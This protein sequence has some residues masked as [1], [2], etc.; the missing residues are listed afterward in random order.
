[1]RS[2][3]YGLLTFGFLAILLV[4]AVPALAQVG[5][6]RNVLLIVADDLGRDLG[7]YGN[8]Q[9]KTPRLDQLAGRGVR[10]DNAFATV[11]SC[12][13]SRAVIYSG[14]YTHT[15]GQFGHA[16]PP[17]NLHTH[18]WVESLPRVLKDRGYRTGIIG[19]VH[20]LPPEVYPFD[21]QPE[22][23]DPGGSHPRD[24]VALGKSAERFLD[25][26]RDQPFLLVV[27]FHDP[28]RSAAGFGNEGKPTKDPAEVIYKPED[29][30][31][32]P[33]LPDSPEV[34]QELAEYYQAVSRLDRGTGEVLDALKKSGRD[35]DT[36]VIFVSD[37]G[38][39]FPGAKTT[40]YDAG[41][42]L[43]LI[44]ASPDQKSRGVTSQ[45]MVSWVDIVP[46]ALEWT[47]SK[48]S[49]SLPGRSLLPI[50]EQS[51]PQGWDTVYGSFVFHEITNYYPMRSIRTRR[52]KYILN[53]A[54]ALDFPFASDLHDSKTWQG[55][56]RRGDTQY[57]LRSVEQYVHRPLEELYDLE[58]DPGEFKNV[59]T[60]PGN[61]KVLADLRSQLRRWQ[62]ETKDPWIIK[63]RHE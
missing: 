55:A 50:L 2:T 8:A 1:M 20:V 5:P 6:R 42:R 45:A 56:V 48:T 26:S 29:V 30:K 39:P 7:C 33:F 49:Y 46:T 15:N 31:V 18:A 38:I 40:L 36:L 61:A 21:A 41:V 27:G 34:R 57:G 19:K 28:H 51:N 17:A 63:Y 13:A 35:D 53:L 37:N 60:D 11:A 4:Q 9:V 22:S 32:P 24:V 54:H 16:H 59:A 25:A 10:F 23:D 47:K 44:V 62:Q 52:Y 12:S 58:A 3:R 14:L 43:P